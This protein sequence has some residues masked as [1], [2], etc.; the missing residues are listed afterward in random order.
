MSETQYYSQFT[1][2]RN[3]NQRKGKDFGEVSGKFIPN[4]G[5][6]SRECLEKRYEKGLRI[7]GNTR[8]CSA[9]WSESLD[10]QRCSIQM[11]VRNSTYQTITEAGTLCHYL[12]ESTVLSFVLWGLSTTTRNIQS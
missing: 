4:I 8:E 2:R 11:E 10:A 12:L 9:Y 1:T 6:T 7:E 3:E 5:K